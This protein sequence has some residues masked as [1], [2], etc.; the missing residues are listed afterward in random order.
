MLTVTA[1]KNLKPKEK[2]YRQLDR[3]GLYLLVEPTGQKKW[4]YRF[5]WEAAGKK[6]RP[7]QSLGS[8]PTVSLE[9]AR[10]MAFESKKLLASGINPIHHKQERK[11]EA[12]SKQKAIQEHAQRMSFKECYDEYCRFKTTVHGNT[13]AAWQYDT[14]KKHNERFSNYVLPLI[15]DKA[16]EDLTEAD[17]RD[18]LL[19]IQAHGTLVNRNKV[20][21]VFNGLF[22]YA[23]GK[24]YIK[25]NI[26][27]LIPNSVFV[28]HEP[29]NFKHVTTEV[30]FANVVKQIFSINATFEVKKA[31][32]L[33]LLVFMRPSNVAGLKWSQV[34]FEQRMIT[35]EAEEMKKR[36]EFLI[37]L[38]DQAIGI[39]EQLQPLTA[40][41]S[42]VFHSPYG[43]GK[44]ISRDSLSNALRRNGVTEISP[45]GMRH[46]ASTLLHEK[47]F[48]SDAIELQLSH[49][50]SGVRGVYNKAQYI[51]QR[52]QMMQS[53]SDF[54][55]ALA[56]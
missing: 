46:T 13:K 16:V 27:R 41:S 24:G 17:L 23:A 7:W 5:T 38:S 9:K 30:E 47:G 2:A 54:V 32:E 53:W 14:L 19:K 21:T 48:N 26:A 10:E 55:Y 43:T 12:V 20:R 15:G 28:K 8:F 51:E 40:H 49:V 45:H 33:A 34:D 1:I 31:V 4:Q 6:T 52:K 44:P 36:R 42:F 56:G 35:I 3:D 11:A 25:H 22:D 39:L 37:P 18:V 29:E 50:I